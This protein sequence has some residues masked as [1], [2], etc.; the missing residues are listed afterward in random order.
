MA[1]SMSSGRLWQ[2]RA[3]GVHR[4]PVTL[5]RGA[6]LAVWR[7]ASPGVWKGPGKYVQMYDVYIYIYV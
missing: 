1:W 5:H 2:H 3:E 6:A 7:A 4:G